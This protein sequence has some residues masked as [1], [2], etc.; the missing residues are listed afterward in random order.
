MYHLHQ[1]AEPSDR[2]A[3]EAVVDHIREEM[4][5]LHAQVGGW[6]RQFEKT[7]P[8]CLL[9]VACV[10]VQLLDTCTCPLLRLLACVQVILPGSQASLHPH[11]HN[12]LQ[13]CRLLTNPTTPLLCCPLPSLCRCCREC[14]RSRS[15]LSVAL[16]TSAW[17][18]SMTGE[19]SQ[20]VR[21]VVR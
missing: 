17:R 16:R 9:W 3:L 20:A 13:P 11:P 7:T 1:E 6:D 10:G 8:S 2:T 19:W 12:T 18:P 21:E 15:C 4:E 5:R 14:R